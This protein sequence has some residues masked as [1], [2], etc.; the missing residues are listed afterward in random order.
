MITTFID[1]KT[2]TE[3]ITA[4]KIATDSRKK[5][6]VVV[7]EDHEGCRSSFRLML[8]PYYRL[9]SFCVAEVALDYIRK[10]WHDIDV[11][12]LDN[13][14]PGMSG[15][16]MTTL[17]RKDPDLKHIPIVLQTASY[18]EFL[19]EAGALVD[20]FLQKPF[21]KRRVLTAIGRALDD[22]YTYLDKTDL[23]S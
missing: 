18:H 7:V 13:K 21:D 1:R 16:K 5:Q 11:V 2:K 4:N 3:P 17:I 8:E 12:L 9:T 22:K 15:L 19:G 6:H 20:E 14:L 23:N 10:H